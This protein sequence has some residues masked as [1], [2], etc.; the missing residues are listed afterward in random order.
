MTKTKTFNLGE[1]WTPS[2]KSSE[3]AT[4]LR[5][6][7]QPHEK[8]V[9]RVRKSYDKFTEAQLPDAPKGKAKKFA[10]LASKLKPKQISVVEA[11]SKQ[12]KEQLDRLKHSVIV[13]F[14]NS[15][16]WRKLYAASASFR[17]GLSP[18]RLMGSMARASGAAA[19]ATDDARN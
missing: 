18:G 12:S 14:F 6:A 10:K 4:I 13:G 7:I 5:Q 3:I 11:I 1:E 19:R 9:K 17:S 2:E 16:A 15:S 8:Y